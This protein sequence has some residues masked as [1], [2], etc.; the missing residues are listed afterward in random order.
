MFKF[1]V[2]VWHRSFDKLTVSET[3]EQIEKLA[4]T[5]KGTTCPCCTRNVKVHRRN[6]HAT[7]LKALTALAQKNEPVRSMFKFSGAGDDAKLEHWGLIE[8]VTR[9]HWQI[10]QKGRDFLAGRIKVPRTILV[11]KKDFLGYE[12]EAE[13]DLIS[14]HDVKPYDGPKTQRKGKNRSLG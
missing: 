8:E 9:H 4:H 12:S 14:V 6:L 13:A 3:R 5:H 1:D 2:N 11:Y 7:M 10:T